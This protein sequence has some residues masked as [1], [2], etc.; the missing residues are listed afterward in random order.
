MKQSIYASISQAIRL[1]KA[2][3]DKVCAYKAISYSDIYTPFGAKVYA[4]GVEIDDLK[5]IEPFEGELWLP[6]VEEIDLPKNILVYEVETGVFGVF[7]LSNRLLGLMP[8]DFFGMHDNE[9]ELKV[10]LF[11]FYFEM[12]ENKNL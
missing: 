5:D 6:T 12:L 4:H 11:I 9:L 7:V 8:N 3:F 2:G 10:R 1:K